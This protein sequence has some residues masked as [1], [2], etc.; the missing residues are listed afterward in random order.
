[1]WHKLAMHANEIG[2]SNGLPDQKDDIAEAIVEFLTTHEG[3]GGRQQAWY[4]LKWVQRKLRSP[5]TM[6]PVTRPNVLVDEDDVGS[7]EDQAPAVPPAPLV[8]FEGLLATLCLTN[9]WRK[10]PAA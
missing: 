8:F 3:A 7:E 9:G 10:V 6:G 5:I 1:M 4:A 2:E